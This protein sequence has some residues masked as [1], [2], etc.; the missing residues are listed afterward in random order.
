MTG[1]EQ[2]MSFTQEQARDAACAPKESQDMSSLE[3]LI[4]GIMCR[5]QLHIITCRL[6]SAQV[7]VVL[8]YRLGRRRLLL[9]PCN[10]KISREQSST[11]VWP[12]R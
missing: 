7:R 4:Q 10:M 6:L 8:I 1:L 9:L 5:M 12:L 2:D 3:V 11:R